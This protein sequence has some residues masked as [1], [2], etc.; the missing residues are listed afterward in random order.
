M[1]AVMIKLAPSRGDGAPFD[2]SA[3]TLNGAKECTVTDSDTLAA[4]RVA[5]TRRAAA[6]GV[7]AAC[8]KVGVSRTA[9]YRWRARYLAYGRDGLRPRDRRPPAMPNR[10]SDSLTKA[11]LDYAALWPTHGPARIA[12]ELARPKWGAWKVSASGV[13]GLLRRRGLGTRF[14]RLPLLEENAAARQ[15]PLTERTRQTARERHIEAA[16]PGDLLCLDT[17]YVGRLKGVG[18]IWQLA[19]V[20][21]ACRMPSCVSWEPTPRPRRRASC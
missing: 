12:C 7:A 17:F 10:L 5:V 2:R 16:A 11:I 6:I 14:E 8:R 4:L 19:C 13:Y 3:V 1:A 15:G 21:A 18:K 9:F 20:D